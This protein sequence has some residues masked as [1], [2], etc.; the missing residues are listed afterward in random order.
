MSN[1]PNLD[2]LENPEIFRVNRIDA[3]SDHLYYED[4]EHI[5]LKDN[6]PLRQYLNGKW[7]F[8][9]AENPDK[10]IKDFYREDFNCGN[11]D[12]IN[13]PGHIQLQGYDN[14]QYINTLYPWDGQEELRP[15][16]VSKEYNPVGSYIKYF[17][18]KDELKN[19]KIFISF[20]GVE[21]AFYFWL[22]GKFIGYSEDSFTPSEFELTEYL[23]DGEN[24]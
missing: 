18:L 22:N 20:Q 21:T 24:K 23:K 4:K 10:R 19:K 6:M 14:L 1:S 17:E 12:E 8:S 13:V 3:H 15:P 5:K 16:Y 7:K 2:W 11:F 9:Y